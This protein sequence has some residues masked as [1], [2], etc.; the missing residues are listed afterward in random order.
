VSRSS[1]PKLDDAPKKCPDLIVFKKPDVWGKQDSSK[2][3]HATWEI[4]DCVS[5]YCR[6]FGDDI[7]IELASSD[8]I[9]IDISAEVTRGMNRRSQSRRNVAE[10]IFIPENIIW[11]DTKTPLHGPF[12]YKPPQRKVRS[13]VLWISFH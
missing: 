1:T 10:P 8:E 7:L 6:Q 13:C 4:I 5:E 9:Y 11:E 3:R 2:T 12:W